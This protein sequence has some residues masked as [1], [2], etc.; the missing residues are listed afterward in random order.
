[1]NTCI[2]F[3][4]HNFASRFSYRSFQFPKPQ[5]QP[6]PFLSNENIIRGKHTAIWPA[7]PKRPCIVIGLT[8]QRNRSPSRMDCWDV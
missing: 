6:H 2:V 3:N 8:I 7:R 5:L 1:M 4:L